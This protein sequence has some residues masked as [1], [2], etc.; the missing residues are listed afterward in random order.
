MDRVKAEDN[1][2]SKFNIEHA[3]HTVRNHM[4]HLNVSEQVE[5]IRQID[6][7]IN[8][9]T[10]LKSLEQPIP[11]IQTPTLPTL[12]TSDIRTIIIEL[13][14]NN[15]ISSSTTI[16]KQFEAKYNTKFK[17]VA[18]LSFPQFV[19]QYC[20]DV[21]TIEKGRIS[22][23]PLPSKPP[24]PK[25]LYFDQIKQELLDLIGTN[26]TYND[27][28]NKF[29]SKHGRFKSITGMKLKPFLE[30]HFDNLIFEGDLVKVKSVQESIPEPTNQSPTM[31]ESLPMSEPT[32]S[33]SQEKP[34][35][36]ESI[37]KVIIDFVGDRIVTG[38]QIMEELE[39]HNFSNLKKLVNKATLYKFIKKR[40]HPQ[41]H[42]QDDTIQKYIPQIDPS[43][44]Y[45]PDQY[46]PK[47]E[48]ERLRDELK[49]LVG[50]DVLSLY[51]IEEKFIKQ[52]EI[53]FSL[54]SPIPEM[55][56]FIKS[57][58]GG[59]LITRKISYP[60]GNKLSNYVMKVGHVALLKNEEYLNLS[61]EQVCE[62]TNKI[63]EFEK[64]QVKSDE[65]KQVYAQ[66][67]KDM[68]DICKNV[69]PLCQVNA[70]GSYA[71]DMGLID[72]DIDVHVT[73]TVPNFLKMFKKQAGKKRLYKQL[74]VIKAK[75]P[76]CKLVT[77]SDIQL[78]VS[79][80]NKED[81]VEVFNQ[82]KKDYP[83]LKPLCIIL[84]QMQNK[85]GKNSSNGGIA[86]CTL[87][88]LVVSHLQN[89]EN[90][91][92]RPLNGTLLGQLF[93]DF[94]YFYCVVFEWQKKAICVKTSSYVPI[95]DTIKVIVD[96]VNLGKEVMVVG[97]DYCHRFLCGRFN[98]LQRNVVQSQGNLL[99]GIIN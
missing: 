86:S 52:N 22:Q 17:I 64:T 43:I 20:S 16:R 91:F 10:A 9:R 6:A 75:V 97:Q 85:Y 39:R 74:M 55:K 60:Q 70:F 33:K 53:K 34:S 61:Q 68:T 7:L 65:M 3:T 40:C 93:Y 95:E 1:E 82:F 47:W 36:V 92:K 8:A 87:Q 28:A 54:V 58:C 50:E 4:Q 23:N 41:L 62:M 71:T 44:P 90:N 83:Q 30:K 59:L 2:Q 46:G 88:Y 32:K 77:K 78:D 49:N 15:Q 24:Q 63:L 72:H 66:T 69:D 12:T 25:L 35:P 31:P 19:K 14:S 96:P 84:K 38:A 94:I 45:V 76:V 48:I 73:T 26:C 29:Q 13:V 67:M 81:D 11:A 37:R 51:S 98:V 57:N 18:K 56:K 89:Y 80:K 27:I 5:F 79:I 42:C 21:L 99:D